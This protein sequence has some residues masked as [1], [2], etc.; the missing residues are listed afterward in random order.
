[1]GIHK[2]NYTETLGF[3][4]A[5]SYDGIPV[6]RVMDREGQVIDNSQEPQLDEDKLI[7]MYKSMTMLNTMDRILYESQRQVKKV[8]NYVKLSLDIHTYIIM[9]IY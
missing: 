2:T 4:K 1:M 5:D 7:H 6:Y 9:G 3:L 8:V